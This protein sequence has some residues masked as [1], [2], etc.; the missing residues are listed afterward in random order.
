MNSLEQKYVTKEYELNIN[1]IQSPSRDFIIRNSN[2]QQVTYTSKPL[3]QLI[4]EMNLSGKRYIEDETQLMKL[5]ESTLK[6][7]PKTTKNLNLSKIH[8]V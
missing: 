4:S 8:L 3:S 2:I 7:V 1:D 6:L 5:I